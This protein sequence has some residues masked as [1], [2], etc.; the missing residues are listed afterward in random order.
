M[1]FLAES[2]YAMSCPSLF[3]FVVVV[4]NVC[5]RLAYIRHVLKVLPSDLVNLLLVKQ[6]LG[7]KIVQQMLVPRL[8]DRSPGAGGTPVLPL[9]AQ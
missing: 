3:F 9:N 1:S 2:T 4:C 8:S 7:D 5:R 6:I